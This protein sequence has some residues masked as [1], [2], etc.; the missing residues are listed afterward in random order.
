MTASV[1]SRRLVRVALPWLRRTYR[2]ATEATG[3][4]EHPALG[5]LVE[6]AVVRKVEPGPW[7]EWLLEDS[8]QAAS[9]LRQHPAGPCLRALR[10]PDAATGS[11]ACAEPVQLVPAIDRLRLAWPGRVDLDAEE[12]QDIATS[13]NDHLAGTGFAVVDHRGPGW[14][15]RCPDGFEAACADPAEAAG[16]D[17]R[18]FLPR[19]RDA[20]RMQS[21]LNE[22]QML[23]H[24]HPVNARRRGASRPPVNSL[25]VWGIG[26]SGAVP[27]AR[28]EP[29]AS[30]DTWLC[31]LW[32]VLGQ[33]G[34]TPAG[35]R[36][37]LEGDQPT[38]L[39]AQ[40]GVAASPELALNEVESGLLAE[41]RRSV[42]TGT[43]D[44]VTLLAGDIELSIRRGR[45]WKLWRR[46]PSLAE[47]FA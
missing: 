15:L 22:I 14:L 29:L 8:P 31:G 25:W 39:V 16:R 17:L 1:R 9:A 18:D 20:A 32:R 12:A 45:G 13:L 27:P 41:L 42:A 46:P 44:Q 3:R 30:D 11:W 33:T 28:L 34:V 35:V 5:W 10:G 26:P 2:D 47:V 37:L 4:L 36:G 40:S 19:G 23:L 7:R 6:H 43:R 21:V 38:V 24:D